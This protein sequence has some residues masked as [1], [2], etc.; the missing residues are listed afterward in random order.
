MTEGHVTAH[1]PIRYPTGPSR[2]CRQPYSVSIG[3]PSIS[4]N[5]GRVISRS[6][7]FLPMIIFL[8]HPAAS[9][10][11]RSKL[12]MEPFLLRHWTAPI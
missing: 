5:S 3:T 4:D 12:A 11:R 1:L 10:V 9:V 2:R 8:S 7:D 6:I